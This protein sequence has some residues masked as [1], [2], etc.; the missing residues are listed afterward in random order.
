MVRRVSFV[1]GG[2]S[3]IGRATAH[4]FAK[5]GFDVVVADINAAAAAIVAAEVS[6]LGVEAVGVGCDV[7]NEASVQ[8]SFGMVQDRFERLDVLVASAGID[9]HKELADTTVADWRRVMDVNVTGAF[10]CMKHARAMMVV[11]RY[12]R[13]IC[14]G[15][16]S[17]IFG[18]GWPAYSSAKA[19][20][21]GLALSA[22][23]ELAPYG[24]TVNVVAPGPTETPLSLSMWDSNPG[25][26]ERLES[27]MPVGRVA[28]P[29]EIA[30]A[31]GYL[32]SESAGYVTGSTLVI[33]GGL[34]SIMRPHVSALSQ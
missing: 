32:A 13:M 14:M 10:L 17:G 4:A 19:A 29:E 9:L 15:S 33:D 1:T 31:I 34:T 3:G 25:R 20:L 8:A 16:S 23:R 28:K 11:N 7:T 12:G 2:G 5:S 6:G 21:Q 26:R 24:I 30:A 27:S 18:M 22:A